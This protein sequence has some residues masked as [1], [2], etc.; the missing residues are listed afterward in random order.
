MLK[1]GADVDHVVALVNGG[2]N[3]DDNLELV[4][5]ECH[6]VKTASDAGRRAKP[7]ISIDGYPA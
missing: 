2:T 3:D 7:R 1:L 4:C 6:R 5:H